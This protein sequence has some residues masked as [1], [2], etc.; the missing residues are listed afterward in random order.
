MRLCAV[1]VDLDE[2]RHYYAIHGLF[3]PRSQP[4]AAHAVYDIAL[5]RFAEL[6]SG[7]RV[8]LTF[9]VVGADVER[10]ENA[11]RLARLA[12]AGHEMGNHT[13]DHLYDLS[14]RSLPQIKDQIARANDSI[15]E[16]T[17]ERPA[18]FR[19]PGY[20][21]NDKVYA[22]VADVGLAYSSSLFPCPYY[23]FAKLAK[24]GALRIRG[25]T[26]EA[27]L[28]MPR[29]LGAP[30]TPYHVGKPYWRRGAGVLELPI[31]VTPGLRL[32]FI[33]TSLALL[34][35]ERARWLVRLLGGRE[36]VNLEL[37]GIDLL[38]ERDHQQTLAPHQFDLRIPLERKRE[39]LVSVIEA[40]RAAGYSFVRLDEAAN[41]YRQAKAA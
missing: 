30:T 41:H 3:P 4:Q 18:G 39:T 13:Y 37:H 9:F 29:V 23:Y 27:I 33:G 16:H 7:S 14:R 34:G 31:Q 25:M 24:L 21:M 2:M 11:E 6:A 1:S 10:S 35:P 12:H 28:D 19:A 15:F 17:G 36:L 20:V 40:L 5:D 22:A 32:P 26:S 38:D 8:P